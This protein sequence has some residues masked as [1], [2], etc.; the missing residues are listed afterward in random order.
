MLG[1]IF[2]DAPVKIKEIHPEC[3]CACHRQHEEELSQELAQLKA[4]RDE[5]REWKGAQS[6]RMMKEQEEF[7]SRPFVNFLEELHKKEHKI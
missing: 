7:C 5:E 6:E 4:R 1:G 3:T 2:Y